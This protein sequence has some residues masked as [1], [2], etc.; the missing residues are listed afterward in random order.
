MA[1]PSFS[2]PV[3][4]FYASRFGLYPNSGNRQ[5]RSTLSSVSDKALVRLS[6]QSWS[7]FRIE[8]AQI[9]GT[10][11]RSQFEFL[12]EPT[13]MEPGK[14]LHELTYAEGLP[15]EALKA[16]LLNVSRCSRCSSTRSK[17]TSR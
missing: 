4:S 17:P 7:V 14:I 3:A 16:A 2:A 5:E 9:D 6:R 8:P 11:F 12:M 10:V 15:K 1:F 13:V